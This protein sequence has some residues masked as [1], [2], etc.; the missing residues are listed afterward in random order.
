M[1]RQA[2]FRA[3]ANGPPEDPVG[4]ND[5][6]ERVVDVSEPQERSAV[7]SVSGR[8]VREVHAGDV[9][10]QTQSGVDVLIKTTIENGGA[11]RLN[12]LC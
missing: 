11:K 2:G 3:N 1:D 4:K 8:A 5:M 9:S 6:A 7:V 10:I 12:G